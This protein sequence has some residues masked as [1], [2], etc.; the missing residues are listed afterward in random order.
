MMLVKMRLQRQNFEI[1]IA[2]QMAA[3]PRVNFTKII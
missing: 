1:K 2:N 3:D